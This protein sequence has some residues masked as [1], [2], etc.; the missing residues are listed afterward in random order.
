MKRRPIEDPQGGV[1]QVRRPARRRWWLPPLILLFA[2]L[3][4]AALIATKPR[5]KPVAVAERAWL[6][7]VETPRPASY[8]PSVTLYGRVESL[9]SSEL[10]AGVTA[11]VEAGTGGRG[12]PGQARTAA[13]PAG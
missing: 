5:P 2:G 4:A 11:D 12:R 1:E 10:T 6:V 13:G 3:A 9:W 8:S 7:S